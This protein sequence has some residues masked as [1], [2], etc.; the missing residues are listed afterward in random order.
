MLRIIP[1]TSADDIAHIQE[2]LRE[3]ARIPG[4]AP[5]VDDFEREVTSLPGLYAPPRGTLL[6][7]LEDGTGVVGRGAVGCVAVRR[8][9]EGACEMKR[10]YVRPEFRGCGAGCALVNELIVAARSMGYR[11]MLLDT[12]PSMQKA[13]ELYRS[14]GFHEIP[15][16]RKKCVPGALCFEL[17]L[18][19]ARAASLN[20]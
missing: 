16:Y 10:L 19:G 5:C 18:R 15:P 4:V 12:L 20:P 6:L 2:L 3:Y 17:D 9:D 13:Q 11:R 8:W 7:A 14:L 1:A